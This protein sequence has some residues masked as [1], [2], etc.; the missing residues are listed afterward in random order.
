MFSRKIKFLIATLLLIV[1]TCVLT[2]RAQPK[3]YLSI[4]A[5]FR[6]EARFLPEW[7][8]YHR[9]HGVEHFYLLNNLSEDDYRAALK[10]YLDEG[11]VELYEWPYHGKNQ[12]EWNKIQCDAY[13]KLL[14]EKKQETTWMAIIDT[15]EF[16]VPIE[17][18]D[19]KAF[20][21]PYES[22]GGVAIN[23]QLFGT[24][25]VSTIPQGKTLI[26]TLTHR[27]PTEHPTN[28]FYKSI[29]QPRKVRKISQPH[30]CHYHRPYFHVTENFKQ[31]PSKSL[32]P[33][34]SINKIKLHHYTYRDELF[35][36]LEKQKRHF[37]WFPEAPPLQVQPSYNEIEDTTLTATA[38][39]VEN[40]LGKRSKGGM[41]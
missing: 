13:A 25:N 18:P 39:E 31:I 1:G 26:G 32:S 41:P 29:V 8:E 36:K 14:K 4:C 17:T 23:W 15:D 9:L 11:L 3:Y 40:Q 24:S 27:A 7:I 12:T 2:F 35:F 5:I 16:L 19:L 21:K 20:L 10:P 6:N 28:L 33:T 37:E 34:V 30:Y 38:K 22:Y